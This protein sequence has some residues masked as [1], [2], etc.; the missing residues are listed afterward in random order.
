MGGV[1]QIAPH[2]AHI[3]LLFERV[4][5]KSQQTVLQRNP[6]SA[7]HFPH[8]W[9]AW[10][11]KGRYSSFENKGKSEGHRRGE[12]GVC[13][14]VQRTCLEHQSSE[15]GYAISVPFGICA[16]WGQTWTQRYH[17]SS[18]CFKRASIVGLDLH[19][20]KSFLWLWSYSFFWAGSQK[21]HC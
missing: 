8:H 17:S 7:Y 16:H 21:C 5:R 15:Q 1:T 4:T 10:R 20:C 6:L 11:P 9:A 3:T 13:S 19:G 12:A 18:R 2:I 14:T